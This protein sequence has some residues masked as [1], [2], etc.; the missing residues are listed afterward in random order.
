[1]RSLSNIFTWGS[2]SSGAFG[3]TRCDDSIGFSFTAS[4]YIT[5][6]GLRNRFTRPR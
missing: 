6:T 2:R 4:I 5:A 1:M 3:A